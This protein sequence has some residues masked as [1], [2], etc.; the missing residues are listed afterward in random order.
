MRSTVML[1]GI[2]QTVE[3]L[4]VWAAAFGSGPFVAI[5]ANETGDADVHTRRFAAFLTAVMVLNLYAILTT[6]FGREVDN[7]IVE[8]TRRKT[9][10]HTVLVVDLSAMGLALVV[11][12]VYGEWLAVVWHVALLCGFGW[13]LV[14]GRWSTKT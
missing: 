3:W 7:D 6:D 11:E 8:N 12:W 5:I 2:W 4:T 13:L 9:V 1:M 10:V 14:F